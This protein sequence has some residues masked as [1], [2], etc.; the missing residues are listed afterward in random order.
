VWNLLLMHRRRPLRT[1]TPW[2][3]F[4][5]RQ[6]LFAQPALAGDN[7]YADLLRGYLRSETIAPLPLQRL[8]AAY[9]NAVFSFAYSARNSFPIARRATGYILPGQPSQA[10]AQGHAR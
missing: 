8:A 10:G 5:G 4:A 2:R 9:P 6:D 7:R 3:D 1:S